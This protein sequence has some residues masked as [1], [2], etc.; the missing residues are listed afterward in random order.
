MKGLERLLQ[1]SSDKGTFQVVLSFLLI[2]SLAGACAQVTLY[3]N[4]SCSVVYFTLYTIIIIYGLENWVFYGE[5][6]EHSAAK[7][8]LKASGDRIKFLLHVIR[9]LT[10]EIQHLRNTPFNTPFTVPKDRRLKRVMSTGSFDWG[11]S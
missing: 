10:S 4:F 3:L 5:I 2:A 11:S 7:D 9:T 8:Q 6:L 1:M